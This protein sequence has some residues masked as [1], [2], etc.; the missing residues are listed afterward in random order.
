MKKLL[1]ILFIAFLV[2]GTTS[3]AEEALDTQP[4]IP[5]V[6][7]EAIDKLQDQKSTTVKRR[8]RPKNKVD[9]KSKG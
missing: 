7:Q 2:V 6:S 3:C 8:N 1:A 9:Y 4:V 5:E